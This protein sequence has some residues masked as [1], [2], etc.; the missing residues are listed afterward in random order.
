[1]S[2]V[3]QTPANRRQKVVADLQ[4]TQHNPVNMVGMNIPSM[5]GGMVKP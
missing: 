2:V 3:R 4:K 5:Y 1:M